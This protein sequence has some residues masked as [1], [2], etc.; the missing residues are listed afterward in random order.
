MLARNAALVERAENEE[1]AARMP[2]VRHPGPTRLGRRYV[3]DSGAYCWADDV[4]ALLLLHLE[5]IRHDTLGAFRSNER[6]VVLRLEGD[7]TG[8]L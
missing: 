3:P 7:Y 8:T 5:H 2:L 1:P 4:P 6:F